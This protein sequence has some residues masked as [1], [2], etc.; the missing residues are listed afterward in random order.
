MFSVLKNWAGRYP[1]QAFLLVFN[2]GV[3]V[4][5]RL[6]GSAI[7]NKLALGWDHLAHLPNWLVNLSQHSQAGLQGFFGHTAI[8]WLIVSMILTL[9][10]HFIKGLIKILLFLAIVAAGI[11]LVYRHQSIL[12]QLPG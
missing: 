12:G 2:S 11:Y 5:L 9:L 10:L 7:S 4:W 8:T 6:A 3:F 1:E